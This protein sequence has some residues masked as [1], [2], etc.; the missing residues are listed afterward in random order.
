MAAYELIPQ[1]IKIK[2]TNFDPP[3]RLIN[4]I[5]LTCA[6]GAAY[7]R[8]GLP[9]PEVEAGKDI[10]EFRD[11]SLKILSESSNF[12]S[13]LRFLI[14]GYVFGSDLTISEPAVITMKMGYEQGV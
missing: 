1:A 3:A 10:V 9:L 6:I 7:R 2:T 5:E 4:N 14:D 13:K 8:A 11:E 12:D